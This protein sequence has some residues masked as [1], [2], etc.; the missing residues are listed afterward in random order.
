[1]EKEKLNKAATLYAY[2]SEEPIVRTGDNALFYTGFLSGTDWLMQQPLSE[3]LTE[4]E[5]EKIKAE[6]EHNAEMYDLGSVVPATMGTM[7]NGKMELL[8]SIFGK[9]LFADLFKEK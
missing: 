2:G 1:M 5:K 6:F 4:E 3:R 7:H 8:E 9:D